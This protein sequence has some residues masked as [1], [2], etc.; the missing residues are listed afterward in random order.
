[1]DPSTPFDAA[2]SASLLYWLSGIGFV[3]YLV[4]DMLVLV[5]NESFRRGMWW[6]RAGVVALVVGSVLL[7]RSNQL[8][9]AGQASWDGLLKSSYGVRGLGLVLIIVSVLM[10]KGKKDPK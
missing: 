10:M 7:G 5:R 8:Y 4:L 3:V 2:R 6:F 1:M 9:A